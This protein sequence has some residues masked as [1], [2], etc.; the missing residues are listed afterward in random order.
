LQATACFPLVVEQLHLDSAMID[1]CSFVVP[2][3]LWWA[4][5]SCSAAPY[6]FHY[7]RVA[8][9]PLVA[10]ANVHAMMSATGYAYLYEAL[11][12]KLPWRSRRY[13]SMLAPMTHFGA[14]QV[15][16]GKASL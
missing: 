15:E 7:S 2:Q 14:A 12:I 9:H 1:S 11:S 8:L 5:D 16:V 13:L 3:A 6:D 4:Q 10:P